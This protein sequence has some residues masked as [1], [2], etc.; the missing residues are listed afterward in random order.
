MCN[1]DVSR[2]SPQITTVATYVAE[3]VLEPLN[4]IWCDDEFGEDE[5]FDPYAVALAICARDDDGRTVGRAPKFSKF[6]ANAF[7]APELRARLSDKEREAVVREVLKR[8]YYT[9][10]C[11]GK[12]FRDG[13]TCPD[14]FCY[15]CDECMERDIRDASSG[16]APAGN[17][18][19]VVMY[20]DKNGTSYP[21]VHTCYS[22]R[23]GCYVID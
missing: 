8:G 18:K 23:C 4:S 3:F 21:Y 2:Y 5:L 15:V 20:N 12:P 16:I 6:V 7:L 14:G 19:T 9:C 13:W 22:T 17:S 11:C 10:D 1:Y